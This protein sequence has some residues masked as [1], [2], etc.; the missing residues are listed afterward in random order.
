M[1]EP[2]GVCRLVFRAHRSRRP[3]GHMD[4]NDPPQRPVRRLTEPI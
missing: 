1:M 2:V 4:G 3:R